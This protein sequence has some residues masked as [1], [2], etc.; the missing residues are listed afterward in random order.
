ERPITKR[1]PWPWLAVRKWVSTTP[2]S[3]TST[4]FPP[5]I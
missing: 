3:V 2:I 4:S 5:P 1:S